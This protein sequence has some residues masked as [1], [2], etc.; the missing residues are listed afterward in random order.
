MSLI[1][2]TCQHENRAGSRFCAA[3]GSPLVVD[4]DPAPVAGPANQDADNP[5]Q[6]D[7]TL[8]PTVRH[9]YPDELAEPDVIASGD[10]AEEPAPLPDED[11]EPGLPV[12]PP[13][14]QTLA[15]LADT[16]PEITPLPSIPLTDA[17]IEQQLAMPG[18]APLADAP[19]GDVPTDVEPADAPSYP[20]DA[21]TYPDDEAETT[22]AEDAAPAPEPAMPPLADQPP[23]IDDATPAEPAPDEAPDA[24][25]LAGE[26]PAVPT[27][28]VLMPLPPG[29]MLTARYEITGTPD[30]A[31]ECYRYDAIDH[32]QCWS[33]DT[34]Q[35][36]AD[37]RFCEECGAALDHWPPVRVCQYVDDVAP[38]AADL[39]DHGYRFS[40]TRPAAALPD[41]ATDQPAVT[42]LRYTVG[43][44]THPGQLRS[45]N[46]DSL[47]VLHAAGMF[48]L[49][50]AP[51]LGVFAAADGIG[52]HDAGEV[53]SR[54][55]LQRFGE[56]ATQT[57]LL[58]AVL[59]RRFTD[60]AREE[61]IA[62]AIRAAHLAVR[63]AINRS[64]DEGHASDMGCTLTCAL[65]DGSQA[66][67]ANVGDSRTY[68]MRGG[69][70][71][72]LTDDHSVVGKLLREG[73]ITLE[74]FYVHE[75]RSVILRSLGQT[76]MP[77]VDTRAI[78]LQPGDRVMLCSD[79]LWEMVRDPLME[80]TLL[81][82]YDT[83]Q[84]CERLVTLANAAGGD[85]NITVILIDVAPA[86]PLS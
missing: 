33:C 54:I 11:T 13:A 7:A 12:A 48:E 52:G 85:D 58:P 28:T 64:A 34:V 22:R 59:G 32:Q 19:I 66:L 81:A 35:T 39:R 6:P 26:M 38:D 77:Q 61:L 79:G 75:D 16:P 20:D 9:I 43:Y 21:P 25:A 2:T 18:G 68:L 46:E 8:I 69:Q 73:R 29:T 56:L 14:R 36:V 65:L 84:T 10:E 1:C 27:A 86:T 50:G 82:G 4:A 45:V 72:Q 53:A 55:A 15:D 3:C 40:V 62:N 41:E 71:Q 60:D 31:D 24:A 47:L 70:L 74:E 51:T 5:P 67:I 37:Q 76:E 23:E 49:P 78:A 44:Q 83:Q 42:A 30:M 57:L 17:E 80:E 63:D